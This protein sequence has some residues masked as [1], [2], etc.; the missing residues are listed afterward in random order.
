MG[1][2]MPGELFIE[3][4]RSTFRLWRTSVWVLW[5][6]TACLLGWHAA[7][8]PQPVQ[9]VFSSL[10]DEV[11]P[12][13]EWAR[14]LDATGFTL[15][16]PLIFGSAAILAGGRQFAGTDEL[17][18]LQLIV[19]FPIPRWRIV[20][21]KSLGVCAALL[22]VTVIFGA[23]LYLL[24]LVS[25]ALKLA[26]ANLGLACFNLFQFA[27]LLG[28]LALAGGCSSERLA[29]VERSAFAI[30]TVVWL[31]FLLP[32]WNQLPHSLRAWGDLTLTAN[33]AGPA[34]P[35]PIVSTLLWLGALAL[36]GFFA[37]SSFNQRDL[38]F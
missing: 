33:L 16:F 35:I 38:T 29:T 24:G 10:S 30:Q 28:L 19:T 34:L 4:V 1:L 31:G 17:A 27:S 13:S 36:I 18:A 32:G 7:G 9:Q 8:V 6:V 15:F 3:T 12:L 20:L 25:P 26:P 5:F 22:G 37:A 2:A 21:E 14:W 11:M 23:T